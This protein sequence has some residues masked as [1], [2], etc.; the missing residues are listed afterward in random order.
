MSDWRSIACLSRLFETGINANE[1]RD[2]Y[3]LFMS[4]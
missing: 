3:Q 2:V 4:E 1:L